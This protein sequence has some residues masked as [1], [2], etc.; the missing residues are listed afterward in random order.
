MSDHSFITNLA[1]Q[2]LDE[3]DQS[4]WREQADLLVA[5]YCFWPDDYFDPD[6]YA[7]IAPY[8]LVID[9][10]QFHYPPSSQPNYHWQMT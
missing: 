7:K 4:V 5:E 10:L 3:Q 1:M 8:Q 6:Q 9:G 2:S